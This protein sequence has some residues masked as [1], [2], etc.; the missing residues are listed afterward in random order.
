VESSGRQNRRGPCPCERGL[1]LAACCLPWEEAFQRLVARL[2]L[3][4]EGPALAQQRA[5]AATIFW[6]MEPPRRPPTHGE[7]GGR[8]HFLE[9]LLHEYQPPRQSGPPIARF[10][11]AAAGLTPQEEALLLGLLLAPMRL[12]EV[13]EPRGWRGVVLRDVQAGAEQTIGPLALPVLPIRGDLLVARLLSVG[14]LG[15][16]G[17]S[18]LLLPGGAREEMLAYL[19][20]AFRLTQ[21]TRHVPFEDFLDRSTYLFHHFH[22]LRGRALGG[23]V[24]E[25]VRPFAYAPTEVLYRG[26]Q[27]ARI[28][29]VLDRQ[30]DLEPGPGTPGARSYTWIERS[31]GCVRGSLHLSSSELLVRADTGEDAA[32]IRCLVEEWLRGLLEGATE[33]QAPA[34]ESGREKRV[35]S[36]HAP[37]G[38]GF[39]RGMLERWADTPHPEL[40]D[41][42][43][44]VASAARG[45]RQ[46]VEGL[47]ASLE[48]ELARSRRQGG[49]WS[50]IEPL[51]EALGLVPPPAVLSRR[52]R[53]LGPRARGMT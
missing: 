23:K 43:P 52:P 5:R 46:Q 9:W 33:E 39:V 37:A 35:E 13:T 18:A 8:M 41:R 27:R 22:L 25:T 3:F 11:D 19:R 50:E 32:G 47:L 12:Y 30:S 51:R 1:P 49:A 7:F 4:A 14:R 15:R 20:T 17:L 10:A 44:R 6:N 36:E 21:S 16:P 38:S 42:P 26:T 31:S 29:A 48:R 2:V 53:G 45:A 34:D 28:R 24:V 40:G